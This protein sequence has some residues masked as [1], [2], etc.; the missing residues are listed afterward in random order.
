MKW[1][2]IAFQ[3]LVFISSSKKLIFILCYNANI[4]LFPNDIFVFYIILISGHTYINKRHF[5]MSVSGL[6]L[7]VTYGFVYQ[8]VAL[9]ARFLTF[10]T[11]WS[12]S[13]FTFQFYIY[14]FLL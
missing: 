9:F 13:H 14:Q 12:F 5:N 2:K 7:M 4:Y 10:I 3:F 1:S 6:T 8:S 11:W